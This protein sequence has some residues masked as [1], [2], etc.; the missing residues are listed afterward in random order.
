[1]GFPRHRA[2]SQLETFSLYALSAHSLTRE[3]GGKVLSL[4]DKA[5]ATFF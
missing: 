2:S 5:L 3:Y 4:S 1:M